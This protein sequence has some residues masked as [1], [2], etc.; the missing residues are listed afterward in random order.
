MPAVDCSAKPCMALTFDDGPDPRVTPAILDTLQRHQARA[1]FFVIGRE[2]PGRT[3]LLQR[4][5]H[6]G[7]EIGNHSWNHADFTSLSPAAMRSE[8]QSTSAALVAAGLPAPTLFRPPYGAVNP[9][10]RLHV[11]LTLVRWDID[12]DDW[13]THD[14]VR[15]MESLRRDAHP[16]AIILMHDKYDATALT[17]ETALTELS[18]YYQFVT[19]SQLL[20]LSPGDQGQYFGR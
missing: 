1:T 14:P 15:I 13:L 10:V 3:G 4:M 2:I 8:W 17:L 5:Y 16:G 20:G 19:V 11:P 7:H 18:P 6:E 9:A 12:T